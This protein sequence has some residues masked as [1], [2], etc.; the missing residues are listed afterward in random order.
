MVTDQ[1]VIDYGDKADKKRSMMATK[2]EVDEL[3][4][5]TRAWKAKHKE[6][7]VGKEFSLEGF[8]RGE[9]Q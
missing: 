4:E 2:Q 8:L 7:R 3:D 9:I 1:P 5:L 6:S